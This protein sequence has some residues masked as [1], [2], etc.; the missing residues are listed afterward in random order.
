VTKVKE[1]WETRN[2]A[3]MSLEICTNLSPRCR[4]HCPEC[5]ILH[6]PSKCKKKNRIDSFFEHNLNP[7]LLV[8][9]G[10]DEFF[11]RLKT[12]SISESSKPLVFLIFIK[13]EAAVKKIS[14][15]TRVR[16]IRTLRSLCKGKK[17]IT[18]Y[19]IKWS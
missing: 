8:L 15:V 1:C 3:K 14:F 10:K 9:F 18:R 19:R 11:Y 6:S 17:E 4:D 2:L 7:V 12:P 13:E 5:L 16:I